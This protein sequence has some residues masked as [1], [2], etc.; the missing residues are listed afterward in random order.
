MKRFLLV[1]LTG[2]LLSCALVARAADEKDK[3]KEGTIV[4]MPIKRSGAGWLGLELKDSNFVL[5]FYNDRKKPVA[6]DR[7]SAVVWWSVHY[8]PNAER[9]E[10]TPG[11]SPSVLASS[12]FVKE[13]HSFKVHMTLLETGTSDVESYVV[14]FAQ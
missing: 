2:M 9:T 11:G 12:Y 7:P 5:T 6:A 13:P 8:Q 14:D 3:E 4:G 10:L 1:A